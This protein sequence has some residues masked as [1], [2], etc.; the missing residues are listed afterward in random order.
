MEQ[1]LREGDP[2]LERD[3]FTDDEIAYC[4]R[5]PDP[6]ANFAAHFALKEAVVKA[7]ALDDSAGV[8]WRSVELRATPG[9][10]PVV[11]LHAPLDELARERGV[12]RVLTSI[13]RARGL[14]AAGAIL[15][16]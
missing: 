4:R 13:S 2:G 10:A 12:A 3:L 14:V 8:I 6:A 11:L 16:S 9:A 15:E 7:L 5:Q 1:A